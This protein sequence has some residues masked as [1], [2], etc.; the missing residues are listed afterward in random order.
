MENCNILK[1]KDWKCEF[2][3]TSFSLKHSG[4]EL[5]DSY[6]GY[7]ELISALSSYLCRKTGRKC[8]N[9]NF[10]IENDQNEQSVLITK[11]ETQGFLRF[12]QDVSLHIEKIQKKTFETKEINFLQA[13]KGLLSNFS[14][15]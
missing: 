8:P 9:K 10:R 2:S 14:L 7:S 4:K 5:I 13:K 6:D 1:H 11:K 15:N 12:L 3:K